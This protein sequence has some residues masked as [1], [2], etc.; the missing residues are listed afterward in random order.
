MCAKY[1]KGYLLLGNPYAAK[2]KKTDY[3][4]F[5]L[6]DFDTKQHDKKMFFHHT[7]E[8]V[9]VKVHSNNTKHRISSA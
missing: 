6:I 3:T 8:R 2:K 9:K 7:S 5:F 4:I 1:D